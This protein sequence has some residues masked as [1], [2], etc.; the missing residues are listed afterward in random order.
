[1]NFLEQ[2]GIWI[3]L[4]IFVGKICEVAVSTIRI[5]LIN[6]GERVKGSIIAVFE[7]TLWLSVTG[8]VLQGFQDDIIRVVIFA[9]AFAFGNFVGSWME[10]KL[11]FGLCSLQVIVPDNEKSSEL[12]THL[13]QKNFAVTEL[14]GRGKDGERELMILHLKRRRIKEATEI[15]KSNLSNA[16]IVITDTKVIQGGFIKK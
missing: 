8:T 10:D 14:K 16:V 11:A 3:Y 5:V 7:M 13:R 9:L 12:A 6:R 15:I 2:S 4:F 1:M